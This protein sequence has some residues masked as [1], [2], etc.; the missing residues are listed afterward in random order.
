MFRSMLW[1]LGGLLVATGA[2][3]LLFSFG[4]PD[5]ADAAAG[6]AAT[7]DLDMAEKLGVVGWDAVANIGPTGFMPLALLGLAVGV[8][9]L[10]GLNATAWKHTGGY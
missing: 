3:S 5:Q 7:F 8:P 2:L 4:T 6:G 9:V 1:V 10:I